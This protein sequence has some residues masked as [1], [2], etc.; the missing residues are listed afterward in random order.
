MKNFKIISILALT[1]LLLTGG[2]DNNKAS[3]SIQLTLVNKTGLTVMEGH[4][5]QHNTKKWGPDQLTNYI[6][7]GQSYRVTF[8]TTYRYWDCLFV[9][10][11]GSKRYKYNL[12][13]AKISTLN[14][15]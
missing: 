8:N 5:S 13:L 4:F 10:S 12:D 6:K 3:A 1:L 7:P 14:I 15:T 2:I 9:L 11:D